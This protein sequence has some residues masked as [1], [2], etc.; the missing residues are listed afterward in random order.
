MKRGSLH[1]LYM[2]VFWAGESPGWPCPG[3]VRALIQWL[4]RRR[5]VAGVRHVA[6]VARVGFLG[7]VAE[8][9]GPSYTRGVAGSLR[10][11]QRSGG[12][13]SSSR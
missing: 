5:L 11:G 13:V 2:R 1:G 3:R 10:C 9:M 4:L 8:S 12:E 7:R 6:G